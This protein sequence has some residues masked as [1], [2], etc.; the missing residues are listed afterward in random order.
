LT[1]P[2]HPEELLALVRERLAPA[3]PA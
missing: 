3:L 1:K 2:F